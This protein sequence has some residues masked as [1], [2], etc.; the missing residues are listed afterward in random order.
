MPQFL[1]TEIKRFKDEA[2]KCLAEPTIKK[3]FKK[4]NGTDIYNEVSVGNTQ[5]VNQINI[6]DKLI[7][8]K[9]IAWII[10]F[11]TQANVSRENAHNIARD[12]I[13]QLQRYADDVS[14]LFPDLS[15]KCSIVFT[16]IPLLVDVAL[17]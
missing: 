9:E 3:A 1:V 14:L 5:S 10:D 11:K 12:F 2:I 17:D 16:K 8:S 15:I 6:I 4:N 7:I 13:P